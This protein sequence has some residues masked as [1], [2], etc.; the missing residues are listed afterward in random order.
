MDLKKAICQVHSRFNTHSVLNTCTLKKKSYC[1][2]QLNIKQSLHHASSRRA[3]VPSARSLPSLP[4]SITPSEPPSIPK[5]PIKS[6]QRHSHRLPTTRRIKVAEPNIQPARQRLV[7]RIPAHSGR[8]LAPLAVEERVVAIRSAVDC[9]IGRLDPRA[10]VVAAFFD[11]ALDVGGEVL[12]DG[13]KEAVGEDVRL[14]GWAV[15]GGRL[16]L[17]W[18]GR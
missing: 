6:R 4:Q 5:P 9:P 18:L 15:A 1:T 13:D 17:R 7:S 16:V 8:R 10:E 2:R 12:E 3:T 14:R 11:W